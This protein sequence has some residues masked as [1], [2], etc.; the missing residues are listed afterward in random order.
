M[1]KRRGDDDVYAGA[2]NEDI[3]RRRGV[4]AKTIG[5]QRGSFTAS[6]A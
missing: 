3:A 4:S 6:W 1:N 2:S 5:N